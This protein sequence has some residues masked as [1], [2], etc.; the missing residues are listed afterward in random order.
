MAA[1]TIS[2]GDQSFQVTI[3]FALMT[4]PLSGYSEIWFEAKYDFSDADPGVFLKHKSLAGVTSVT[5]GSTSANGVI[6]VVLTPTDWTNS[7]LPD[8]PYA[9]QYSVKGKDASNVEVT[10]VSGIL[11]IQGSAVKAS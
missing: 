7:T 10:L 2:K 4:G 8:Y 9:L 5:A 3:P 6:G 1:V 11:F